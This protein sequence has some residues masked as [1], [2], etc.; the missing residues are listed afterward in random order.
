MLLIVCVAS[1]VVW[2]EVKLIRVFIYQNSIPSY[3]TILKNYFINYTI[4]FYNT[5]NIPKLY[6]FSL[7][8][9]IFYFIPFFFFFCGYFSF[10]LPFPLFPPQPLAPALIP[11]KPIPSKITASKSQQKITKI[12]QVPEIHM[13]T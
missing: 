9:K 2:R 13:P 4:L 10:S 8:I 3:F 1:L 6:F 11:S 7:F 12:K 5:P